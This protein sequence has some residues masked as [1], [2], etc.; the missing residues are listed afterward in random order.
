MH[1]IREELKII[2]KGG[3]SQ[4]TVH[5]KAQSWTNVR[6]RGILMEAYFQKGGT[7]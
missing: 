4:S 3:D 1:G 7:T 2:V 6:E 5:Q